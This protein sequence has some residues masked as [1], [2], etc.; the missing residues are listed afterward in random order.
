MSAREGK[1]FLVGAGPGDPELL[2]LKAVRALAQADLVLCDALVPEAILAHA[3][4][5][6]RIVHV[7]KRGGCKSTPQAFI[8]RLMI[9]AARRGLAVVRLKGGDPLIFGRGAEEFDALRKAGIAYE[10]INGITSGLAAANALGISLTHRALC[11]GAVLVTGHEH[12]AASVDWAALAR[13]GL[14]LVI[15]MGVA[16]SARI[17]EALLAAGM[18]GHMPAA[19]VSNASRADERAIVTRLDRLASDMGAQGIESPAIVIVGEVARFAKG[20]AG[21]G[22]LPGSEHLLE[23]LRHGTA[24]RLGGDGIV[25]GMRVPLDA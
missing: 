4:Q 6:A 22:D 17:Q 8:E 5:G 25:S 21:L 3:R 10:V 7:G 1:V 20:E 16:R 23:N 24:R 9:A 14:P 19:A 15:Y 18:P 13:T 11:H 12:E 2:T